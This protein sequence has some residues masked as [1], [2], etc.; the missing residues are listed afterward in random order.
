LPTDWTGIDRR[1]GDENSPE[2]VNRLLK[3][4]SEQFDR[5]TSEAYIS[6]DIYAL[7]VHSEPVEQ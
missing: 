2:F 1:R 4:N 3:K 6:S 7:V 5:L